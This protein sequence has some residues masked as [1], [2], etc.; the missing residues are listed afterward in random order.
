MTG[1]IKV[2]VWLVYATCNR[3]VVS[4]VFSYIILYPDTFPLLSWLTLPSLSPL[5]PHMKSEI[6]RLTSIIRVRVC[7]VR[8][9][10][11]RS[12]VGG[13]LNGSYS[14]TRP[15]LT[16]PISRVQKGDRLGSNDCSFRFMVLGKG[17]TITKIVKLPLKCTKLHRKLWQICEV[18][19]LNV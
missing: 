1:I 7:S 3:S 8:S 12:A 16:S 4:G 18:W 5:K 19:H 17:Q 10:V 6:A 14:Q 11:N 13:E 2:C 9:S 15:P